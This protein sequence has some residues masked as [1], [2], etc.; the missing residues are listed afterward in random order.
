[1]FSA[2]ISNKNISKTECN[3]SE[4]VGVGVDG[5]K[6]NV[7]MTNVGNVKIAFP[8]WRINMTNKM[9]MTVR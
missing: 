3:V 4:G 5:L 7:Q 8:L 1:M 2:M 6:R 9:N